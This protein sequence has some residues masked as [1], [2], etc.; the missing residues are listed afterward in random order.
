MYCKICGGNKKGYRIFSVYMCRECMTELTFSS[1]HDEK[2]DFYISLIRI[3]LGY[4]V[5]ERELQTLW[6]NAGF[7]DLFTVSK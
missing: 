5:G 1:V 6:V 3:L 7:Y 2:Y 4:Y